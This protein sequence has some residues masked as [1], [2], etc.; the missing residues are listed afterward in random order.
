MPCFPKQNDGTRVCSLGSRVQRLSG[1]LTVA[2]GLQSG[3][4]FI[5]FFIY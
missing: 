2:V 4:G 1:F 5:L 3:L